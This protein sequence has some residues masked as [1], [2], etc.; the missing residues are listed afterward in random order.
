MAIVAGFDVHR[1]QITFDAL[2]QE[3]G[4]VKRGRMRATPE[5]VREAAGRLADRELHVALGLNTIRLPA[6][7]GHRLGGGQH[8]M[9]VY[10]GE[11]VREDMSGVAW[12]D[13]NVLRLIELHGDIRYAWPRS[14]PPLFARSGS[15]NS[16]CPLRSEGNAWA[17]RDPRTAADRPLRKRRACG[18]AG[19]RRTEKDATRS[20]A[21]V[22]RVHCFVIPAEHPWRQGSVTRSFRVRRFRC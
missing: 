20:G 12:K 10:V 8:L 4:E 2:D 3:T 15:A 11:F 19:K 6:I 16:C 14:R 18:L 5:A 21:T 1:A 17:T 9:P 22:E 7:R 13:A